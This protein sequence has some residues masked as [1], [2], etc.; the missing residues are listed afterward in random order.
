M[1]VEPPLDA[2]LDEVESNNLWVFEL[3]QR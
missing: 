2:M 1:S 3:V